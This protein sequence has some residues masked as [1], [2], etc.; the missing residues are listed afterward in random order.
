MLLA[1]MS[2]FIIERQF[3]W[4]GCSMLVAASLSR[5]RLMHSYRWMPSDTVLELAWGNG[6]RWAI[7]YALLSLLF[8]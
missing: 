6:A 7:G 1:A 5:I 8:F 3:P 4:A 2:V